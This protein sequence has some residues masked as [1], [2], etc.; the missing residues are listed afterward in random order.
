MIFELTLRWVFLLFNFA[1]NSKLNNNKIK[2]MRIIT[3]TALLLSFTVAGCQKQLTNSEIDAATTA[4]EK[5]E[6]VLGVYIDK[7]GSEFTDER[8]RVQI[9]C[10]D[11]PSE[12]EKNYVPNMLKLS[13]EYTESELLRDMNTTLDHYRRNENI[14]C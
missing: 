6:K 13:S 5:S 14:Q 8:L 11:Y 9:L 2:T 7:L 10:K 3:F 12:Y 4:L 1:Y